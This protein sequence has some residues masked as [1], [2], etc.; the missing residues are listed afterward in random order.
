MDW[1]CYTQ[2]TI[3]WRREAYELSGEADAAIFDRKRGIRIPVAAEI[4]VV[5]AA[6]GAA[7]F[8]WNIICS[9]ATFFRCALDV[10]ALAD[11]RAVG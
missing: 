11:S 9:R 3:G 4:V 10:P 6:G 5:A 2:E 1:T 8:D 7:A